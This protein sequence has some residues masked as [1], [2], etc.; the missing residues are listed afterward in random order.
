MSEFFQNFFYV[1]LIF[2]F[3][4]QVPGKDEAEPKAKPKKKAM[5]KEVNMAAIGAGFM[6]LCAV[7]GAAYYY[8]YGQH[9]SMARAAPDVRTS[10]SASANEE[11]EE[12]EVEARPVAPS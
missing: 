8:L 6:V 1:E 10:L 5:K 4:I 7:G 12:E 3:Y 2:V 11:E 9:G